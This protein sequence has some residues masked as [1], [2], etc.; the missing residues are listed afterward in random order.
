MTGRP[1]RERR[2]QWTP[3]HKERLKALEREWDAMN[4]VRSV[5]DNR[6]ELRGQHERS[7]NRRK[8]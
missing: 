5:A 1:E 2:Q 7:F 8:L 3:E 4:F 6:E